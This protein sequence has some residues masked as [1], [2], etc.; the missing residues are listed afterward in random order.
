MLNI[1]ECEYCAEYNH[2][3]LYENGNVAKYNGEKYFL[4]I[5]HE[6]IN[7]HTGIIGEVPGESIYWVKPTQDDSLM[8][9][10]YKEYLRWCEDSDRKSQ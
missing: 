10:R 8:L 3:T 9:A 6:D 1:K 2:F 5:P 4:Y 7:Y